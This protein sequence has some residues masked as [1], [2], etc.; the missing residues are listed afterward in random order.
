MPMVRGHDGGVARALVL[1]PSSTYRAT[2]FVNAASA[3]G[4]D[5][6][7]GSDEAQTVA[8]ALVVDFGDPDAAAGVIE[9]YHAQH[10]L[11]GIVAADDQGVMVAALAA[12]RLGLRHN[13]PEAA[14][15]TRDKA[16]LRASLERAGVPQ[17]TY[18][19][20]RPGADLSVLGF[21]AVLKPLSLAASRGVIRVDD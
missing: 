2:D 9:R 14:A 20:V 10:P 4:V 16:A 11:D 8:P 15:R 1:L 3:L 21:P 13:P 5:L 7:V 12:A 6:I 19:V 17:P 18:R